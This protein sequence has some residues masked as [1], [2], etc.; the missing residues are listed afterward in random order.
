MKPLVFSLIKP[1]KILRSH[2]AAR[3]MYPIRNFLLIIVVLFSLTACSTQAVPTVSP[4]SPQSETEVRETIISASGEVVPAQWMRLTFANGGLLKERMIE[5]GQ[6]VAAGDIIARVDDTQ[7]KYS[8]VQAEA[9]LLRA[10]S[11]LKQLTDLPDQNAILAA[12]AALASAEAN[13]DQLKRANS[14]QINLDAAQAQIDSL[15]ANLSSVK[16]SAALHQKRAAE[17]DVAAAEAAVILA[18]SQLE[19]TVLRAPFGGKIIQADG[20]EGEFLSPGQMVCLLASFNP[21]LVRTTDLS[22]IDA[23]RVKVG[24]KAEIVFDAFPDLKVPAAITRIADKSEQGAGVYFTAELEMENP[25]TNLRWG[26][27]AFVT[28]VVP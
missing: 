8:V 9:N 11:V 14:R 4:A 21:V 26:M 18:K 1:G 7:A 28:I 6:E 25:P 22:E 3:S 15:K 20:F 12:E 16:R 19:Q 5:T 23:A 13:Y 17:A 10:R 27:S 24:Q 2:Q